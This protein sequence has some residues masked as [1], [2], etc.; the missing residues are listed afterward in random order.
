M[1]LMNDNPESPL[2]NR[3]LSLIKERGFDS[4]TEPQRLAIPEILQGNNILLTSPTGSGKTEAA[5]LPAMVMLQ[6]I[7]DKLQVL[8]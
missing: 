5:V 3:I 8:E 1:V 6:N 4:L 7:K 2:F